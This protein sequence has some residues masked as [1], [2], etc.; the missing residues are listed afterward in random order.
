MRE[1][2]ERVDMAVVALT[3]PVIYCDKTGPDSVIQTAKGALVSPLVFS[4]TV[5]VRVRPEL[6]ATSGGPVS[7]TAISTVSDS[8]GTREME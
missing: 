1:R 5:Q 7:D 4:V 2:R 6:P 8:D 3:V